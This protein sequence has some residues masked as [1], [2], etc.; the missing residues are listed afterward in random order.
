MQ[1]GLSEKNIFRQ[2]YVFMWKKTSSYLWNRKINKNTIHKWN[3]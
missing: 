3:F 1:N 2:F